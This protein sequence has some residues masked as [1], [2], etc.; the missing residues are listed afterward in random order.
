MDD[1]NKKK[2]TELLGKAKIGALTTISGDGR[3]ESRPMGLQQAEFDGDL[4]F[5]TYGTTDK[6]GQVRA[7]PNVN[8]VVNEGSNTWVSLSGQAEMV[9]DRAKTRELWNPALKAWFPDGIETPGLAL[10]RVRAESAEYWDAANGK[11]VQLLG[12]A[13][14]AVT[15]EQAKGGENETVEL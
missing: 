9:E 10:I 13:K 5:F 4:W 11:V 15:G 2:V 12:F 1:D 6:V 3:L 8:V 7:N 14:A